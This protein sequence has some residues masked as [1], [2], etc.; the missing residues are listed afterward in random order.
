MEKEA[1]KHNGGIYSRS[2]I[3]FC[4]SCGTIV[5]EPIMPE[6]IRLRCEDWSNLSLEEY[7]KKYNLPWDGVEK[8]RFKKGFWKRLL[9]KLGV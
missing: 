1:C 3:W 4:S 2:D 6:S 7:H 8:L 9:I 5:P